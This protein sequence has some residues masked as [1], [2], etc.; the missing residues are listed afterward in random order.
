MAGQGV[1]VVLS[2]Y[3]VEPLQVLRQASC[4]IIEISASPADELNVLFKASDV[5]GSS[6]PS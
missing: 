5:T 6:I 4:G 2:R 1:R 3:L